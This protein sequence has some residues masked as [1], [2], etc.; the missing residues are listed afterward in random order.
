MRYGRT[1]LFFILSV[2]VLLQAAALLRYPAKKLLGASLFCRPLRF[3]LLP[4]SAAG[5][6]SN[7]THLQIKQVILNALRQDRTFYSLNFINSR[8]E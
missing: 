5:G 7:L 6:G 4:V 1:G 2:F 8:L 3:V